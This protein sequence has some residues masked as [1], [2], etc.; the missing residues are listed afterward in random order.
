ML[1]NLNLLL[2]TF[3]TFICWIQNTNFYKNAF[4][5][6]MSLLVVLVHF[7]PTNAQSITNGNFNSRNSGWGCNP[8]AVDRE[9]TYGGSS[10]T[11]RVAEV[12]IQAGLCQTITGFTIG[13]EYSLSFKCSRRTTCG[14]TLQTMDV[15][16]SG[17][18]LSETVSRNGGG[19]N[20]TTETFS[21]VANATSHTLEFEGTVSGTCGLILD[22]IEIEFVSALPVD[23]VHF[24]AEVNENKGVTLTWSTAM[25]L[26]NDYLTIERSNNGNDWEVVNEVTGAGNSDNLLHYESIDNQP[27][28]NTSYYRLKQTD[29]DG[30]YAYSTI[31]VITASQVS[32]KIVK[33]YP[34]PARNLVT[35][36][37]VRNTD[38]LKV[39]NSMGQDLTSLTRVG[40]KSSNK[41]VQIN[42]IDL[43]NGLYH[44][45]V[46]ENRYSVNKI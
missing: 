30:T 2:P 1:L 33:S 26:N 27:L 28:A 46:G 7:I 41:E 14:P 4:K 25:E 11:N 9:S 16:I 39:Y 38:D 17:G 15:T 44:I 21:F 19:F 31:S 22:D 42:I 32:G 40:I 13:S 5:A 43:P 20:F 12:D 35:L 18:V 3:P 36:T 29:F 45:W 23:L 8:E 24:D 6:S 10:S 34:N 37:E